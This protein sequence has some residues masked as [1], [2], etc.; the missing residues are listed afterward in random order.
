MAHPPSGPRQHRTSP[1]CWHRWCRQ[2]GRGLLTRW[3][4]GESKSNQIG[5]YLS[6]VKPA[7]LRALGGWGA[8]QPRPVA[9]D[10]SQDTHGQ[11]ED[12]R[13][14][15]WLADWCKGLPRRCKDGRSRSA[16]QPN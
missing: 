2:H 1:G 16:E 7:L 15:S 10:P 6:M 9:W 8:S 3:G 5:M 12:G 13:D 4:C 11:G 14:K